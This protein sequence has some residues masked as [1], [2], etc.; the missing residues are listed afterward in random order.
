MHFS[1]EKKY[2]FNALITYC[3]DLSQFHNHLKNLGYKKK[4]L[5]F[6]IRGGFLSSVSQKLA[7]SINR[8]LAAL[9][10]FYGYL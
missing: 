8:K 4:F 10:S 2:S 5:K 1:Y 9:I 7:R 3:H 6:S